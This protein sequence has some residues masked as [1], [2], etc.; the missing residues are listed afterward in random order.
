MVSLFKLYF[1]RPGLLDII[2]L[3]NKFSTASHAKLFL[4]VIINPFNLIVKDPVL[5]GTVKSIL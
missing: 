1:F 3:L 5:P 2:F 4:T